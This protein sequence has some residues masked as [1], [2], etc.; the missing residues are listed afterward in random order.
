MSIKSAVEKL[1]FTLP[2]PPPPAADYLV[3][4]HGASGYF[5]SGQLPKVEGGGLLATGKV[6]GTVDL[7]TARACARQCVLN[8]LSAMDAEWGDRFEDSFKR[9]LKLS[10]FVSSTPDFT[11]QHLVA[12]GASALIHEVLGSAGRHARAAV[13]CV[14]LPL[15]APVEVEMIVEFV[16]RADHG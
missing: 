6:G 8:A 9:V 1:G 12:D 16:E 13:G 3:T 10:V 14:S 4:R 11:D 7:D 15:D 2:P 5:I